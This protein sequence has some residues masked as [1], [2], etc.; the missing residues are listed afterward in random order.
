MSQV[1]V[2]TD[3]SI[4]GITVPEGPHR[5]GHDYVMNAVF[6]RHRISGGVSQLMPTG[7]GPPFFEDVL[8]ENE[9][10]IFEDTRMWHNAPTSSQKPM[11][12]AIA[13]S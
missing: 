10:I 3:K 6:R 9:A 8:Q 5:D 13:T 4:T 1:R 7:G 2:I 12:Q 11:N